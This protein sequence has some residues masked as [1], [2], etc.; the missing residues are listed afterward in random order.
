MKSSKMKERKEVLI[1]DLRFADRVRPLPQPSRYYMQ[2]LQKD[3]E[4]KRFFRKLQHWIIRFTKAYH[5]P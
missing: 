4:G 2:S 3:R 1:L 5:K